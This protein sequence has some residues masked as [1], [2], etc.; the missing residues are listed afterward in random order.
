MPEDF[1]QSVMLALL[2]INSDWC[3]I[4]LPHMT[5]VYAG[6]I[7]DL[8]ATA[9]NDLAKDAYSLSVLSP[10]SITLSTIGID[11][12]G[13]DDDDSDPVEVIKLLPTPRLLSMREL[14]SRWNA[15]QYPFNPHCTIGPKG[16][17]DGVVP[18]MIAFDRI[19]VGY[20]TQSIT[21]FL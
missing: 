21:F 6:Q 16:S 19:Y 5:L 14:V 2:P 9:F 12:F 7:P 1:S 4:A 13:G 3:K 11:E 10:G 17:Y 20:G 8:S 15:S 18:G